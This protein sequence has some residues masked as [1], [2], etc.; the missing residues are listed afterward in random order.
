MANR[1]GGGGIIGNFDGVF[2]TRAVGW[3]ADRTAQQRVLNVA[4]FAVD[5][6]GHERLLGQARAD[7]PREDLRSIGLGF[8]DHGFE[9]QIPEQRRG[10]LLHVRVAGCDVELPG[11]PVEVPVQVPPEIVGAFDG[12][13][14][15]RAVGWVADRT[16]PR[17]VLEVAFFAL[18]LDGRE[19]LLGQ[20]RANRPRED[21]RKQGLEQ[22]NHGFDWRVPYRDSR[23]R[24]V[25]RVVEPY[26]D[27]PGNPVDV[28]PRP[29]YEGALDGVS[30]GVLT[31]WAWAWDP[32]ITVA[33][34]VHVDRRQLAVVPATVLRS[35]LAVARVGDGRHGFIWPV[36]DGL[37]DDKP[38]EFACRI[39][40]TPVWLEGGPW[41]AVVPP[42]YRSAGIAA[43]KAIRGYAARPPPYGD[44][45]GD[46]GVPGPAYVSS[47]PLV[48]AQ[49]SQTR[50]GATAGDDG[51]RPI[52]LLI[53]VWGADYVARFCRTGLPS[54]LS[55]NNLP[56]LARNRSLNVVFLGRTD[57]RG[58]F[59]EWPAYRRLR[60]LAKVVFVAIDD[61][62]ADY[63][64]AA[65][66]SY[67][68]ALTYAF[69][70]GIRASGAAATETDFIMW[71]ADFIAADGVF[72]TVDKLIESGVRCTMVPSLRV[73]LAAEALLGDYYSADGSV[74]NI[75]SR[76]GVRLGIRFPHPTVK[77]QTVNRYEERM[78]DSVNQLYWHVSDEM[79]VARVFLN[80]ML[81]IRPERLWNNIYG[82]CDYVFAPEMVPSGEYHFETVSDRILILE[83]QHH[84][85]EVSDIVY[86][87]AAMTPAE[88]A[89]G[90][91]RWTT[92]EHRLAS[93]Q[94]AVFHAGEVGDVPSAIR[95]MTDRFMDDVY[96][97]LPTD[98]VW[99]N[100]H[101][102][103]T[104]SLAAS[105][106]PY[107]DPGPNHPRSHLGAALR[108]TGYDID[109]LR[110][111]WPT[112]PGAPI[113][114]FGPCLPLEPGFDFGT[115]MKTAC[116]RYYG[117]WLGGSAPLDVDR[118]DLISGHFEGF[119]WGLVERYQDGWARNLGPDG[120]A[121]LL[122]RV[123]SAASA[124][125][126]LIGVDSLDTLRVVVNGRGAHPRRIAGT[127]RTALFLEIVRREIVRARGCLRVDLRC[128]CEA[129]ATH[130]PSHLMLRGITVRIT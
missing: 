44:P 67:A 24:L 95:R 28:C 4:F 105:G 65:L 27:V 22:T 102:F 40:G 45:A 17:R 31:G 116:S 6:E 34:E 78:I 5:L 46:G 101:F 42:V 39:A 85:R 48:R 14:G 87:D 128:H 63:F 121:T 47:L 112:P 64:V 107:R 32:A 10:C 122:L 23:F 37:S 54:L 88:I 16:A 97:R 106:A 56:C 83:L 12:L 79:M 99:H 18:D 129:T 35:D 3:V 11:G 92:R 114:I 117:D 120:C 2:G 15:T 82:H 61:I 9:W 74:L 26:V 89:A 21:L 124:T 73:D 123:P 13:V 80:F 127:G 104:D 19:S 113:D 100:G 59:E 126:E 62:L 111:S 25:T 77:A 1:H 66:G 81:H 36:P 98:P 43:G 115:W 69:F 70:R 94:L 60:R 38:H 84:N 90:V 75:P 91:A 108:G 29:L 68:T 72:Q 96:E 71:N 8:I 49:P 50:D 76:E 58:L 130:Q 118:V 30:R 41:S 119:G 7:R 110:E 86:A 52:R 103:W 57:E 20:G 51:S 53:P 125:L 93:R 109:V 33:V 55:P